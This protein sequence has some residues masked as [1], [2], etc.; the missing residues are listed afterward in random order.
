MNN[1]VHHTNPC[2]SPFEQFMVVTGLLPSHIPPEIQH[3]ILKCCYY[4]NDVYAPVKDPNRNCE[5]DLYDD[6]RFGLTKNP[7][8]GLLHGIIIDK[9][10]L[11]KDSDGIF[12]W[13]NQCHEWHLHQFDSS[14]TSYRIPKH[15]TAKC[16]PDTNMIN[17]QNYIDSGYFIW[18]VAK[19]SVDEENKSIKWSFLIN[20]NGMIRYPYVNF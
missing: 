1:G 7:V 10:L 5:N 11:N 9:V 14:D 17:N 18:P 2:L 20:P 19:C 16:T 4:E 12:V 13:C 8:Y 3:F 6:P 15:V